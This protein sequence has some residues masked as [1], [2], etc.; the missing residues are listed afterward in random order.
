[1]PHLR[2]AC[3]GVQQPA[4]V[5]PVAELQARTTAILTETMDTLDA[6]TAARRRCGPFCMR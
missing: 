6:A 3:Q 5:H 1:M 4:R 2:R